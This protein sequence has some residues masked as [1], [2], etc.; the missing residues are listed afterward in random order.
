MVKNVCDHSII[1]R[2][3]CPLDIE[4]VSLNVSEL[5]SASKMCIW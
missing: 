3:G 1:A 4:D 5:D 2:G